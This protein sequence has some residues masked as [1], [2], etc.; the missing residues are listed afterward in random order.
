MMDRAAV[1]VDLPNFYSLL[2][3]SGIDT[4]RKLLR[5]YFLYWMD[6]KSS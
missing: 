6:H 2:L 3:R 1:F 4:D 5:D